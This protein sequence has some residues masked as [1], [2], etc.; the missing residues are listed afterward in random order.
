MQ[1]GYLAL[2]CTAATLFL[3]NFG[4]KYAN[5]TGAAVILTFEAVFGALFSLLLRREEGFSI[6]RGIGFVVVFLAVVISETKLSFLHK[7]KQD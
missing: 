1:V 2:M 3:Q 7:K 4:Q 5:P 6:Q